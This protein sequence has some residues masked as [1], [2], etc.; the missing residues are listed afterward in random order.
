LD[1]KNGDTLWADA[2][3]K[4]IAN[5]RLAFEVW[6][7]SEAEIPPGYQK[8]RCHMIF[9]V[10][11]GENFRR[12]ARFVAGGH[13]TETPASLTY[14]SVVSRDSVRIA[15]LVAALND[16]N[17]VVCDIQNAYLTADCAEKIY[18][19]AGT[20]FG[21][22]KG[23]IF[24]VKKA[25][26][27]LKSSGAAFRALLSRTLIG[28][29]YAP[30]RADPDVY[31][32]RAI[33]PGVG[34]YYEM[35]LCYVDDIMV[36]SHDTPATTDQLKQVF[37]LKDDKVEPPEMYLGARLQ[38]KVMNGTDCW[39]MTSDDYVKTAIRNLEERLAKS[40]DFLPTRCDTPLASNAR[41][42]LDTSAELSA[43]GIQHYQ[44]LIGV[45]R[46]ATELG[47]VDILHE[48]SVL[49]THMALP[50]IGHLKH[51]YHIFGY[52]KKNPKRTLAFD[53]SYPVGDFESRFVQYDWTDFYRDAEDKI[54]HDM[55]EPL[56][57]P[58]SL[59]CF[60]DADHA[61][62]R[63]T[64]RSHTGVLIFVNRAPII[65]FSK[66]QNTV[67]TSTFGS[68]FIAMKISVELIEALRY[69]LRMFG[70]RIEKPASVFCDNNSVVQNVTV[71]ESTLSKKHN[72]IAYHRVREAVA[73]GI[74]RVAKEPT[75]TNL[76]DPLTKQLPAAHRNGLFERW[77]Y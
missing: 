19:I 26:Y 12:K 51:V 25:L 36:I 71:P 34:Q 47:R 18:T 21:S 49:S 17:V 27:G 73:A 10:K 60:T 33:R 28:I 9:D 58:V 56:G 29:G 64:R 16:L 44:E 39:T 23:S 11:M 63:A 2:I 43:E 54:P 38:K 55:P 41:P 48:V 57:N 1:V 50:R 40:G 7:K 52:L 45:L 4:E 68:E 70:I 24:I 53:P 66:K 31:L 30:T 76:A 13:T 65:W 8:I 77:M 35:V 62:D 3:R 6:D 74:I 59:Y 5:V 20:E 61:S 15:L 32:R 37:K 42:E 22:E 72:A 69:K 75:E 14:A 46:W 67:E